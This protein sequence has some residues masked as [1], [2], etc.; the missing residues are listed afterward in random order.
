MST[1]LELI[2]FAL[3]GQ[4]GARL[5]RGLGLVVSEI[6]WL[7]LFKR[8]ILTFL[9]YYSFETERSEVRIVS[10]RPLF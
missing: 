3:G 2:G 10:P 8:Q 9:P 5:A 7:Q 4:A 1:A 6:W